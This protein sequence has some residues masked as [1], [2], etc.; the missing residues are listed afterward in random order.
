MM[1]FVLATAFIAAGAFLGAPASAQLL[2]S[3]THAGTGSGTTVSS[4]PG[5]QCAGPGTACTAGFAN[6]TAVTLTAAASPGSTFTGWSGACTGANPCQLVVDGPKAVTATFRQLAGVRGD[7]NGDGKADLFWREPAPG[8]GLSWWTMN[9]AAI[10][11]ANYLEVD[12]A[13][14]IADLG[15]LDGD[16]NADLVWRRA[17][18]GALYLWTLAGLA[19]AGYFDLGIVSPVVWSF[20]GVADLDGDGKG[21]IV[22][23]RNADGLLYGW[24]MNGA[25]I[26][27]QGVI[28]SSFGADMY[29]AE[30]A[31][32]NGDGKADLLMRSIT[33][34][35]MSIAY[36]DGLSALNG[37]PLLATLDT[38]WHLLAA[39]DFDGDGD[40][41]L[42]WRRNTGD[43]W[44]WSM[45]GV[46]VASTQGIGNS[47]MG[48]TIRAVSDFDGDG[49]AD[50]VIRHTDGTTRLWRGTGFL[51]NGDAIVNPGGSWQAIA[52]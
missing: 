44:V 3:V 24:L 43:T 11:G 31:D 13:W 51:P 35:H 1:K 18:D 41:D 29:V 27:A 20:V 28:S 12:A 9:G 39:A 48:W 2:V 7:A 50:I 49:R 4:P 38:S 8:V 21:D 6:G 40:P 42:L 23:R 17:S 36:M 34:G 47:A 32:F 37:G 22:W 19:P 26:A 46:S 45:S 52:P 30:M 5:I 14:Q 10:T 15:D 25:A 16:G 33:A